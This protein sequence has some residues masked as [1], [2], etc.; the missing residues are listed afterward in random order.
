MTGDKLV[1]ESITGAAFHPEEGAGFSSVGGPS[2]KGDFRG[3]SRCST[4]SGEVRPQEDDVP[5]CLP[6]VSR[7]S[8]D[9][10]GIGRRGGPVPS[11]KQRTLTGSKGFGSDRKM[12]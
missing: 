7:V 5:W 12:R 6:A 3:D 10:L 9:V 11:I 2:R 1:G 4:R 8:G